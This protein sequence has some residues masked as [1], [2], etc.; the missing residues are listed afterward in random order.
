MSR[1][2]SD[3][4]L[5]DLVRELNSARDEEIAAG[6]AAAVE[7]AVE[8][9]PAGGRAAASGT[10]AR[11][12]RTGAWG[13]VERQEPL[14]R[15]LLPALQ[16][17]ASD[18][19]LVV[20]AAPVLRVD[21]RLSFLDADA[22][23]EAAIRDAIWRHLGPRQ[24]RDLEELG[25]ADRS[26]RFDAR[27][28]V[29]GVG[30]ARFRVNVHRQR[31]G[32]AAA[33]RM[34]PAEI[35]TLH[36]LG[37]PA[38]LG[39]L[40][41]PSRGLVLVCGPTGSGKSSTLA[42]LLDRVNREREAHVITIEDPVEYEHPHRSCLVEHVEI[43]RDAAS[44][45]AA[46]RAALRQDP[47]V[48]L[49]GELRDLETIATALTAA[50]TGHLIL[51][52]LHTNDVVQAVHR[53]VDVFEAERQTQ[54]RQQLS[55]C[56]HGILSQQ[57]VPRATGGGRVPAIELLL[58]NDAIRNHLRS[59]KVVHLYNEM[60]LGKRAGMVT[61]EESLARLVAAGVVEHAEAMMR[62]SRPEELA[63]LLRDGGQVV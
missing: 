29:P 10:V 30:I 47:D 57:L 25:A 56:L 22:L 13:R 9:E 32:L 1:L 20:G 53:I 3:P 5:D 28:L 35:P 17:E 42:A 23:T 27:D 26:L 49:V 55:L 12:A 46:L 50:E 39:R 43:G 45:A 18:L 44:F 15:W 38:E 58:A 14:T 6:Q 48:I 63:S 37:L 8:S 7:P 11:H 2:P 54:I 4:Q 24:R 21:G 31:G 62:A 16:R 19:L 52:T 60:V 51:A 33:I 59:G 40:V 36:D 61:M 41:G 34:L